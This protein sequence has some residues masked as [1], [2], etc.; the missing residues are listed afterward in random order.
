MSTKP[1]KTF[2]TGESAAVWLAYE[3]I[4]TLCETPILDLRSNTVDHVL[5][6]NLQNKPSEFEAARKLYGLPDDFDLNDFGNWVAAHPKCN[7]RKGQTIFDGVQAMS[8]ILA[9]AKRKGEQARKIHKRLLREQDFAS[10]VAKLDHQVKSGAPTIAQM[11]V[12][13]ELLETAEK[14]APPE[15]Q[16]LVDPKRWKVVVI[17]PW[18]L[19]T[20]SDGKRVGETPIR[21]ADEHM[22]ERWLCV[23]CKGYGPL[24]IDID[25][26][27]F[28]CLECGH[29]SG[30][31][32]GPIE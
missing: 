28:T 3:G 2:T 31:K 29:E 22:K 7:S 16:L 15:A 17:K 21:T 30:G 13:R 19:A 10:V 12:L 26:C 6:E 11:T 32:H 20:V 18:G 25:T 14:A 23:N 1:K 24:R 27:V 8:M 5:P 4:C 9:R